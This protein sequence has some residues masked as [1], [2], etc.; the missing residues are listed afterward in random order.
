MKAFYVWL[1]IGTAM[2]SACIILAGARRYDDTHRKARIAMERADQMNICVSN[3]LWFLEKRDYAEYA[4]W[5]KR[6]HTIAEQNGK[7]D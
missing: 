3:A 6:G 4:R 7:Y 2:I 1:A 5:K